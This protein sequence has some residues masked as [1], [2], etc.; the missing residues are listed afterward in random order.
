MYHTALSDWHTEH[1]MLSISWEVMCSSLQMGGSAA[2]STPV[3]RNGCVGE[4]NHAHNKGDQVDALLRAL[5]LQ[6]PAL[7]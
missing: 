4:A 2:C 7:L 3:Q 5:L 6:L 1:V